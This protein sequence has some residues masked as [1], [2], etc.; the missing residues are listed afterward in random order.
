MSD[1]ASSSSPEPSS[2]SSSYAAKDSGG[3]GAST[4][5]GG[6][7]AGGDSSTVTPE[8]DDSDNPVQD[9]GSWSLVDTGSL[10]SGRHRGA[11]ADEGA[12]GSAEGGTAAASSGRHAA[13]TYTVQEGDSLASIADSLDLDGGWRALYSE[14]K[15][16]IGVDPSDIVPGQTLQL[17]VR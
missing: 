15:G 13:D 4:G 9:E 10:G 12:D 8:S 7:Q 16:V 11:T 1:D 5:K 6:A 2:P 17:S 3:A 14:N